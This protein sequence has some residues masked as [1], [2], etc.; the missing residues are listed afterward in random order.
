MNDILSIA[1]YTNNFMKL[2][3]SNYDLSDSFDEYISSR[4]NRIDDDDDA[5]PLIDK[6]I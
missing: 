3:W 6:L 1:K 5:M 4:Q 2:N